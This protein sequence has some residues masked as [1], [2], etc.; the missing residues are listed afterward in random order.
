MLGSCYA[1]AA[2]ELLRSPQQGR[3][4]DPLDPADFDAALDAAVAG[5]CWGPG[6]DPTRRTGVAGYAPSDA[7]AALLRAIRPVP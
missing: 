4:F 5:K 2:V 3:V 7:A 6:P 1:G